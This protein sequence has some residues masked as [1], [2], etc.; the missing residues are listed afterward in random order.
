MVRPLELSDIDDV[1]RIHKEELHGFLPEL[2][3]P[4]LKKF[5][6]TS[7]NL[8]IMFTYIDEQ[9]GQIAG[10]V[11]GIMTTK[12][13][14]LKIISQDII[15]FGILFLSFIIT[16]FM[17]FFKMMATLAYPGFSQDDPEL[18]TIAISNKYQKKGI[19]RTLF[20][21]T[22]EEFKKR[23]VR[24][25]QISV[26]NRLPAVGF[27]KKIGCTHVRTFDFLGEKMSYYKYKIRI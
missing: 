13:L 10:F 9:N 20:Q 17:A 15:G 26:Y 22:A 1:A 12:G 7:L 8:P 16:H 5:Y 3:I 18:L 21:K 14:F 2:G 19:G 4:F 23:G 24:E 11:S 27:Y 25:F 6:L